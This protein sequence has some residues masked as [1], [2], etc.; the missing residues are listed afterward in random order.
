MLS[1]QPRYEKLVD[2]L[3]NG[4]TISEEYGYL[5][6]SNVNEDNYPYKNN[7]VIQFNLAIQQMKEGGDYE[8][9]IKRYINPA[10]ND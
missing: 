1:L 10:I 4:F 5:G 3:D 9:I 2:N 6:F 7:F 8:E